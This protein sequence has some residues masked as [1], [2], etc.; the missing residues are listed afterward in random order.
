M[1]PHT[2]SLASHTKCIINVFLQEAVRILRC[3]C[4][5][6]VFTVQSRGGQTEVPPPQM[7]IWTYTHTP[8]E[9]LVTPRGNG[10]PSELI[11]A[12]FTILWK[13]I[14]EEQV[15]KGEAEGGIL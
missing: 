3:T 4:N 11:T 8:S 9:Q 13:G 6:D 7:P 15:W 12:V 2:A 10:K 1:F 5:Y 14:K